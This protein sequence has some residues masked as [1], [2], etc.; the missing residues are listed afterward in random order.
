MNV[1]GMSR[2]LQYVILISESL[3]VVILAI[4]FFFLEYKSPFRKIKWI[5]RQIIIG[6]VFGGA[7]IFG[8]EM[9]LDIGSSIINVRDAA[10]LVA[11]LCFGG[12]AGLIAAGIGALER[13][14]SSLIWYKGT[15][16]MLACVIAT[17]TAGIYAWALRKWFFEGKT[18]N[19]LFGFATAAIMEV[20]HFIILYITKIQE[21]QFVLDIIS[22]ITIPM[23]VANGVGVSLACLSINLL[24]NEF[25]KS[26]VGPTRKSI[27]SK[28]QLHLL[29]LILATAFTST[30]FVVAIQTNYADQTADGALASN[31]SDAGSYVREQIT[32]SIYRD[33]GWIADTFVEMYEGPCEH[34]YELSLSMTSLYSANMAHTD[35]NI[36]ALSNDSGYEE[37]QIIASTNPNYVNKNVLSDE[38]DEYLSAAHDAITYI[39]PYEQE[40]EPDTLLDLANEDENPSRHFESSFYNSDFYQTDLTIANYSLKQV[41]NMDVYLQLTLSVDRFYEFYRSCKEFDSG[42]LFNVIE[43][44]TIY[45]RVYLDGYLIIYDADF[46]IV[47]YLDDSKKQKESNLNVE[48]IIQ[49]DGHNE[50]QMYEKEIFGTKS[51]YMFYECETFHFVG[52]IPTTDVTRGRNMMM[53]VYTFMLIFIYATI[54]FVSY[55]LIKQLVIKNLRKINNTLALIIKGDLDQRVT[56]ESSSEFVDLSRDI[57]ITVDTLKDFIKEAEERIDKEL[58]FARTIQSSSLPSVFPAFPGVEEFDIYATMNTAKEVGGDFYDFY[59]TDMDHVV[60]LVADVSGKGIPASMFMME[61]KALIKNSLTNIKDIEQ[62][63]NR[64]NESLSQGNDAN[65]FVTCWLGMV[66][67]RTGVLEF[68][69]AGHNA[70]LIYRKSVGKWEYMNERRDLVLAGLPDTKYH[71]QSLTLNPGDKIYLYTDGVTE[72]TRGDKVLYGETRLKNYLNKFKTFD[73]YKLLASIQKD[74]D[75]FIDGAEQFDDITM[76]VFDFKKTRN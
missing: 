35:L 65:M 16:A 54:F 52:I 10:P 57:N 24:E 11:G 14:L 44:F 49:R 1:F 34:N 31:I 22:E 38:A 51:F 29:I 15:Y 26:D 12:P 8:T 20:L 19:F 28:V 21:P 43:D 56:V 74:I 47:S 76:L 60:F 23:I 2:F 42:S 17:F 53:I 4:I 73:Q 6:V 62:V 39:D 61:S 69:N 64:V 59:F 67:L 36:V 58:A 48:D 68:V 72:A 5:Y 55:V 66:D 71:K 45:R 30:S 63:F 32:D 41:Y 27:N 40:I 13:L 7:A 75:K 25:S 33:C 50:Y 70:P 46:N 37:G 18:P 9:G 3:L